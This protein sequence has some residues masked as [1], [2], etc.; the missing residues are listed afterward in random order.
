MFC[1]CLHIIWCALRGV[2]LAQREPMRPSAVATM[3][4]SM[5]N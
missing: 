3:Q 1:H 4:S 5:L 2:L